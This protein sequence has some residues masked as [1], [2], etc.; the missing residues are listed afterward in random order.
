[1]AKRRETRHNLKSLVDIGQ[2]PADFHLHVAIHH[3]HAPFGV[4]RNKVQ[5]RAR[6]SSGIIPAANAML[7][8]ISEERRRLG[9]TGVGGSRSAHARGGQSALDGIYREV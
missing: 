7:Q 9:T 1:M 8:E 4:K 2:V 6:F 3:F 5:G